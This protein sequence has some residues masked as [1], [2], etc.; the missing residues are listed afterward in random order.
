MTLRIPPEKYFTIADIML[1][2]ATSMA[3]VFHLSFCHCFLWRSGCKR[4]CEANKEI[5]NSLDFD[6]AS[7]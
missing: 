4:E 6:V 2:G 5:P 7:T 3:K 1:E